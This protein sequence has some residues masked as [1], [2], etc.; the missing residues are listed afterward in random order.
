MSLYPIIIAAINQVAD[1]SEKNNKTD[2]N[3]N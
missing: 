3:R 1:Y 2:N